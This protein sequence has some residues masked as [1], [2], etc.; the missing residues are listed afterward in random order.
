M[1]EVLRNF[2]PFIINVNDF[3]SKQDD[4]KNS[5]LN[6][7]FS[8]VEDLRAELKQKNEFIDRLLSLNER[9]VEELY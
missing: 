5:L 4:W 1:D 6:N 3:K 2:D 9:H 8:T 7:L